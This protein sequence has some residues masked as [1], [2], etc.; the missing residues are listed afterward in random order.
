MLYEIQQDN[1]VMRDNTAHFDE[2]DQ[3]SMLTVDI[4]DVKKTKLRITSQQDNG[5]STQ[6]DVKETID[7]LWDVEEKIIN[8]E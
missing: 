5:T 1:K 3:T 7:V 2:R 8:T 4:L 6:H